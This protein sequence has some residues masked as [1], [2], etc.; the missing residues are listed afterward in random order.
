MAE[1]GSSDH[2]VRS[3]R[4]MMLFCLGTTAVALVGLGLS[5]V[6]PGSPT[7]GPDAPL[8]I[9]YFT[10][11]GFLYI[12]LPSHIICGL[13][14]GFRYVRSNQR[15]LFVTPL[16]YFAGWFAMLIVLAVMSGAADPAF[17]AINDRQFRASHKTEI[18]LFEALK[19][20]GEHPIVEKLISDGVDVNLVDPQFG[21]TPLQWA[22]KNSTPSSV[23]LLLN[24]G[25]D[26]NKRYHRDFDLS[27]ANLRQ[28]TVID[29]AAW[30]EQ[31]AS[32][33]VAMLLG[34]GASATGAALVGMCWAG[35]AAL[36]QSLIQAGADLLDAAD[37][38]GKTCLHIAAEHGDQKLVSEL[39]EIGADPNAATKYKLRPLDVAMINQH[40][41]VAVQLVQAG[42]SAHHTRRL[43]QL[44]VEAT[45]DQFEAMVASKPLAKVETLEARRIL[46][47]TVMSCENENVRRILAAG[48]PLTAAA[49][50]HLRVPEHCNERDKLH[51]MIDMSP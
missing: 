44:I 26:P 21:M 43:L 19:Q 20:P 46:S 41:A 15:V 47:R 38:E 9:A 40:R 31:G 6:V 33:K 22:A 16:L 7:G 48:Y 17:E 23:R 36:M 4:A 42:G 13:I 11:L 39:L 49:R 45:E 3:T 35:D 30:S 51:K 10:L 1:T 18:T 25:A 34:A 32:E 12:V 27:R 28:P 29:F 14:T 2:E 37:G 24:A 5:K 8:L 50:Q